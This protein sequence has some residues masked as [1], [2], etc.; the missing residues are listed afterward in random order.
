MAEFKRNFLK[1]KMN[2]DL[3]ERL[4]PDGEYRDA[5]NIEVST[6]EGSNVGSAQNLKG[7]IIVTDNEKLHQSANEIDLR[8]GYINFTSTGQDPLDYGLASFTNITKDSITFKNTLQDSPGGL[9]KWQVP[10]LLIVGRSYSVSFDVSDVNV[11][12]VGSG[13]GGMGLTSSFGND[14]RFEVSSAS[15]TTGASASISGSFTAQGT[16]LNLFFRINSSGTISNFSLIEQFVQNQNSFN[17]KFSHADATT[18]GAYTDES[19]GKIYNFVANASSLSQDGTFGAFTRSTGVKSDVITEYTPSK[20]TDSGT[21][22]PILSDVYNVR[23]A[24]AVEQT[25]VSKIT[26]LPTELI[27][28][29]SVSLGR[30]ASSIRKGMRV[31]LLDP[32]GVDLYGP[33][34]NIFVTKVENI[35]STIVGDS[36]TGSYVGIVTTTPAPVLMSQTLIDTGCVYSFSS[37]RILNFSTGSSEK[38]NGVEFTSTPKQTNITAINLVEDNLFFTDSRNEPKKIALDKFR[39]NDN[40]IYSH[41]IFSYKNK[42]DGNT[43]EGFLKEEYITVIKQSP[44]IEPKVSAIL[45]KRPG[46]TVIDTDGGGAN[47]GLNPGHFTT[48]TI[49]AYAQRKVGGGAGEN[50]DIN[51][52]T[53]GGEFIIIAVNQ[54]NGDVVKP[55]FLVGDIVILVN[56]GGSDSFTGIIT[57]IGSG[58]D[59]IT[60]NVF[61][62][63]VLDISQAGDE[64]AGASLAGIWTLS[65]K[66][67]DSLFPRKFVSFAY[68]YKYVSKQ[69]SAISPYS[70]TVFTPGYYSYSSNEGFNLGMQNL[71]KGIEVSD[72]IPINIPL[73]VVEV[74]LLFKDNNSSK[75]TSIK[76]I[77]RDESWGTSTGFET[78]DAKPFGE[79]IPEDQLL[80]SWDNVPVRATAQE[81]SS[82]R[83]MY[84]NY[85]ENYDLKDSN[86]KFVKSRVQY[87]SE[88]YN[89]NLSITATVHNGVNAERNRE[90]ATQ[91][92]ANASLPLVAY[93]ST[94][95][96]YPYAWNQDN[97]HNNN[98]TL[99]SFC[100]NAKP[101]INRNPDKQQKA[102]ERLRYWSG[103]QLLFANQENNDPGNNWNG[104]SFVVPEEMT[105]GQVIS[106]SVACRGYFASPFTNA[107]ASGTD[108]DDIGDYYRMSN[109][110]AVKIRL[111]EI[112]EFGQAVGFNYANSYSNAGTGNNIPNDLVSDSS[113]GFGWTDNAVATAESTSHF[114]GWRPNA[115]PSSDYDENPFRKIGS[116]FGS[117]LSGYSDAGGSFDGS[118]KFLGDVTVGSQQT[119]NVEAGKRYGFFIE[120]TSPSFAELQTSSMEEDVYFRALS[121]GLT[122]INIT[123]PSTDEVFP[124]SVGVESIKSS[125]DYQIGTV[126]LDEYGRESSVLVD[127]TISFE[128]PIANSDIAS[129]IKAQIR[130]TAP[131]WATHYKYFIKETSAKFENMV[132]HKAFSPQ[133]STIDS[134]TFVYLSF[135]SSDRNKITED[136]YLLVKKKHGVNEASKDENAK[137]KVLAIENNAVVGVA[138]D[139]QNANAYYVGSAEVGEFA[140]V[141]GKFFVKI[142]ADE[143]FDTS[144]GSSA[145]AG[146]S[147]DEAAG[148]GAVFEVLK[149]NEVDLELF[150]EASQ[151]FPIRLDESG[152]KDFVKKGAKITFFNGED[153]IQGISSTIASVSSCKGAL[154]FAREQ[155]YDITGDSGCATIALSSPV[156]ELVQ[157]SIETWASAN[158]LLK[159]IRITNADGSYVTA[160]L[161]PGASSGRKLRIY[162]YTHV[163]PETNSGFS[164][165]KNLLP[166]FNCIAFGNGVESDT[167]RDDFNESSIYPYTAVGK[168]SGFKASLKNDEYQ[169]AHL[170]ND[171]IF[172]QIFN[173]KVGVDRTNEFLIAEPITKRLNSE[174]GSIQKLYQRDGDL[175]A[176]CENKVLKI[177]ASKDALFN[178]DGNAQLLATNRV[179][180]QAIPFVGDYGISKNPE[181]F[182]V[183]E[184]RVYFADQARGAVLRLSRDGIT[185]ISDYGMRDFFNDNLTNAQ[186]IIGSYDGKKEEYNISI[187]SVQNPLSSK[188][189]KCLSYSEGSKGWV[190]FKSF[191]ME[192]AL[193]LSNR[194][195]T[196]KNGS[197][198]LHHPEKAEVL[199]NNFYD[200]QY[201]STITPIVNSNPSVVKNFD[202]VSYSGTSSRVISKTSDDKYKNITA[203]KGW[204]LEDIFTNRQQGQVDS[205]IDKEGKKFNYIK[206]IATTF[207]NAADAGSS[208]GNIDIQESSVQGIGLLAANAISDVAVS[209]GNSVSVATS[210]QDGWE[211]TSYASYNNS[212]FPASGSFIISPLSQSSISASTIVIASELPAW[213]TS[214]S[215][216]DNGSP[217]LASN[218]VT[219]TITFNA[220]DTFA[221]DF[222]ETILLNVVVLPNSVAWSGVVEV[223]G[224]ASL[225]QVNGEFVTLSSNNAT[226]TATLVD[227]YNDGNDAAQ[228]YQVETTVNTLAGAS[229]FEASI[230]SGNSGFYTASSNPVVT[231]ELIIST[232]APLSSQLPPDSV[233][234]DSLAN[235]SIFL[236]VQESTGASENNYV[237]ITTNWLSD[238]VS[239]DQDS[240]IY[241]DVNLPAD[242]TLGI[243]NSSNMI[244]TITLNATSGDG[245]DWFEITNITADSFVISTT[246]VNSGVT[247]RTAQLQIFS[248][249]NIDQSGVPDFLNIT[250]SGVITIGSNVKYNGENNSG[251][252][253]L[254]TYSN[255][256][257]VNGRPKID[258]GGAS[259][260]IHISHSDIQFPQGG[261]IP[262]QIISLD[263]G[264]SPIPIWQGTNGD[265]FVDSIENTSFNTSG[266]SGINS[267]GLV[268]QA[269]NWQDFTDQFQLGNTGSAGSTNG[270]IDNNN[271]GASFSLSLSTPSQSK[272]VVTVPPNAVQTTAGQ[273]TGDYDYNDGSE[274]KVTLRFY[275]PNDPE[276]FTDVLLVQEGVYSS[277]VNTMAF[278]TENSGTYTAVNADTGVTN[279]NFDLSPSSGTASIYAAIPTSDIV[280][281]AGENS[282]DTLPYFEFLEY[283]ADGDTTVQINVSNEPGVAEIVSVQN[284]S[285]EFPEQISVE[286]FTDEVELLITH[287]LT[288]SYSDN[289]YVDSSEVFTTRKLRLKGYNPENI[290]GSGEDAYATINQKQVTMAQFVYDF[291]E[292]AGLSRT[293][294]IVVNDGSTPTVDVLGYRESLED[295]SYGEL[296]LA[297]PAWSS[298]SAVTG[299]G[300]EYQVTVSRNSYFFTGGNLKL[301]LELRSSTTSAD[302]VTDSE[303]NDTDRS[304]VV[305]LENTAKLSLNGV[306]ASEGGSS[307]TTYGNFTGTP[308]QFPLPILYTG[309]AALPTFTVLAW[310]DNVSGDAPGFITDGSVPSWLGAIGSGD[311]ETGVAYDSS[312]GD[313]ILQATFAAN[314]TGLFRAIQ[315]RVTNEDLPDV[316]REHWIFQ[317]S[318]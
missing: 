94:Q 146:I 169:E 253:D 2:K 290:T 239:F 91:S 76:S 282:Y 187:H 288:F 178:A 217:S 308:P 297:Q 158:T 184:F 144:I 105:D 238:S 30:K 223:A 24:P 72:F 106:F 109:T 311:G 203:S 111:R 218:T 36:T 241:D 224:G 48:D 291:H 269:D 113:T 63:Q 100:N 74:E 117:F 191:L 226:F 92:Q 35:S 204:H 274:R 61:T 233:I 69:Y 283:D 15:A 278:Y 116:L 256:D 70:K 107:A 250:Q 317:Q 23:R 42:S 258:N 268:Q 97:N 12:N 139:G 219:A 172:S 174:Y 163:L 58:T 153:V 215:F 196:F 302:A 134:A 60:F 289:D 208:S 124:V 230:G 266:Q 66:Q 276:V 147:A 9:V 131:S 53:V 279:S 316:K 114:W 221:T 149:N 240:Y 52:V 188:E 38:E 236:D 234:S 263:D 34:N 298:L 225:G 17:E 229:L 277:A 248:A 16:Q 310:S 89:K 49:S 43:I 186:A 285:D 103:H 101:R 157:P 170:K 20:S 265:S 155:V 39:S 181:S 301:E 11:K 4:I 138:N 177:L 180:G 280:I 108:I 182:A 281:S 104:W 32:S 27:N 214:I 118:N 18:V 21:T 237:K 272:W 247:A 315:I 231:G 51:D 190:S 210:G 10:G 8:G 213:I 199:R 309:S 209:Q 126:Y 7:N 99:F 306:A 267:A 264:W 22:L 183:D 270:L 145:G 273:N 259:I 90:T 300:N 195:Y 175:V 73:D 251:V 287:K 115:L 87:G 176:F 57:T 80:R 110:V 148:N 192:S 44:K 197:M 86:G 132:M 64:E 65:L 167:I 284:P 252:I 88:K 77:Q 45:F 67:K 295:G 50:F 318:N 85:V 242:Y 121:I 299:S 173:D 286:A 119:G 232:A 202:T 245:T 159:T 292:T 216:T 83:L 200:T 243:I 255:L 313:Y 314:D 1:G 40:S 162:P 164:G 160:T 201:T 304:A 95:Q 14:L 151:A 37:K 13:S 260:E 168:T 228:F 244:P 249:L 41:S 3:D 189:V 78:V 294:D 305:F 206:G 211:S 261:Q 137:W 54:D 296:I 59:N 171:L 205:F 123:A 47:S 79:S 235:R 122:E 150:Y 81:F 166:W 220:P 212:S 254:L 133:G 222:S 152:I 262:P 125:R 293:F 98:H 62:L 194:Y 25:E 127:E 227:S 307:T 71:I 257:G 141:D 165:C 154:S 75:L 84:G 161:A 102:S 271:D 130:N 312:T 46:G 207:T 246:S 68:R 128:N 112:D 193:S 179:L 120:T 136:D 185:P 56:V 93:G 198:Y 303:T 135:N 29:T 5:L 55:N 156:Q 19:T 26:N 143:F 96:F 82:S 275:H 142:L 129:R 6:S 140:D 28:P 31:Q 33:N